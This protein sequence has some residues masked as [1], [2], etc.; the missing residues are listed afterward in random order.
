[1]T[2]R[3]RFRDLT[4]AARRHLERELPNH[5]IFVSAYT[6]EGTLTYDSRI[7][8]FNLRYEIRVDDRADSDPGE[9]GRAEAERFLRTM[10]FAHSELKVT[11]SEVSSVWDVA[12]NS[13]EK[14]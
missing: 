10:G 2:I 5:D 9:L 7:T 14:A 12:A 3:G 11:A 13:E 4:E 1:M 8:F 6:A